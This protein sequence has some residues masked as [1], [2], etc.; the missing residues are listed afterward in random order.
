MN[1]ANVAGLR[2]ILSD[3]DEVNVTFTKTNGDERVMRC[4]T[5]AGIA[6]PPVAERKVKYTSNPEVCPVWDLDA[7]GWRSFR[8]DSVKTIEF[9]LDG[10]YTSQINPVK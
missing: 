2:T 4:T 10:L 5:K 8:F 7:Q 1:E 6:P 9:G 3:N